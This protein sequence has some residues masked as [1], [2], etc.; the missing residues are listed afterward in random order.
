MKLSRK[1]KVIIFLHIKNEKELLELTEAIISAIDDK[2]A[3]IGL[4]T[5]MIKGRGQ[6]FFTKMLIAKSEENI[7]VIDEKPMTLML[8]EIDLRILLAQLE[9]FADTSKTFKANYPEII[10]K[11]KVVKLC[12]NYKDLFSEEC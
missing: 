12:L 7:L 3:E 8:N 10:L 6:N 2:I 4:L 11:N 5:N 9:T 1:S